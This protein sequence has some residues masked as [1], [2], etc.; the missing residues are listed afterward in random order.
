MVQDDENAKKGG[1]VRKTQASKFESLWPVRFY[2]DK[3][4]QRKSEALNT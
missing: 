2:E 1:S 4:M 3:P